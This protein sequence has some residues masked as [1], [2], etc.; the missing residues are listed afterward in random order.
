MDHEVPHRTSSQLLEW[1]AIALP[2]ISRRIELSHAIVS[3][4]KIIL[5]QSMRDSADNRGRDC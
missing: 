1:A 4:T 3:R 5:R 2:D